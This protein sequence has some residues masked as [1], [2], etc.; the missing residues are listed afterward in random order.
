MSTQPV[1]Y[2]AFSDADDFDVEFDREADA[3]GPIRGIL[4]GI[5][6]CIPFWAAAVY[7]VLRSI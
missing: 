5:A 6:M 2:H 1:V 3:L 4:V 7:L